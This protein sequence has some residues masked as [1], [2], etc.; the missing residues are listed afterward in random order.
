LDL[1]FIEEERFQVGK[2]VNEDEQ[3]PSCTH[4]YLVWGFEIGFSMTAETRNLVIGVM[5][6]FLLGL[7]REQLG[8]TYTV[9]V[10]HVQPF[11]CLPGRLMVDFECAPE[12]AIPLAAF[13]ADCLSKAGNRTQQDLD[14]EID[15]Q[16]QIVHHQQENMLADRA[17]WGGMLAHGF[18]GFSR[19][20]EEEEMKGEEQGRFRAAQLNAITL[21]NILQIVTQAPMLAFLAVPEPMRER[22]EAAIEEMKKRMATARRTQPTSNRRA[23]GKR[24]LVRAIGVSAFVTAA[25]V[26]IAYL[27]VRPKATATTVA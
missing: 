1:R 20:E 2:T 23:R 15:R 21:R 6:H 18:R 16:R 7:L 22:T 3:N 13:A 17:A 5:Q 19:E 14:R 27:V 12:N 25:V 26:G 10:Q 24:S 9:T 8:A 11:P 4:V